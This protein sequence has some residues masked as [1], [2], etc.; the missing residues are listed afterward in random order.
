M[1]TKKSKKSAASWLEQLNASNDAEAKLTFALEAWRAEPSA[2][3]RDLVV[4]R[5]RL[6]STDVPTTPRL[7]PK[8]WDTLFKAN[9]ASD[10]PML[11]ASIVQAAPGEAVRRFKKLLTRGLD[12]RVIDT[13]LSW[14]AN[15]P[16]QTASADS[17]IFWK[18]VFTFLSKSGDATLRAKLEALDPD[19][20]GT[21]VIFMRGQIRT[22]VRALE[23]VKEP[24]LSD[25]VAALL[26]PVEE[27]TSQQR[28]VQTTASKR[29]T[30]SEAELLEAVYAAPDD[31]GP[32]LVYAD[33]LTERG[34]PWG[35][36][37]VTQIAQARG[38]ANAASQA[39]AEKLLASHAEAR[40]TGLPIEWKVRYQGA[41]RPPIFRRGFLYAADVWWPAN[42]D[43]MAHGDSRWGSIEQLRIIG[44]DSAMELATVLDPAKRSLRAVFNLSAS[45]VEA[46]LAKQ[47]P[48]LR[49]LG[50]GFLN[51]VPD[52]WLGRAFKH[53][54][55]ST[56]EAVTVD[57]LPQ[58][59]AR[60]LTAALSMMPKM[61]RISVTCRAWSY[62]DLWMLSR[63]GRSARLELRKRV[64]PAT[65]PLLQAA[66]DAI[67][68]SVDE[69]VLVSEK[70][71]KPA[72]QSKV[73][74]DA[75]GAQ[76]SRARV[77]MAP[78]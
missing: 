16:I 73:L 66:I 43:S 68:G 60:V 42:R 13:T 28:S 33:W 65:A 61:Q 20:S 52:D 10:V 29:G 4:E 75:F 1:A 23:K 53:L 44:S 30:K 71:L 48:R 11:T 56:L 50:L 63:V 12:P 51:D 57:A 15:A 9:K 18:Q 14:I 5:S 24:A 54:A 76:A 46:V 21:T 26:K 49:E 77:E 25:E 32:R 58:H 59:H 34:D 78:G 31:D 39:R 70:A 62:P 36:L 41:I 55:K 40:H 64:P 2:R 8:A 47:P 22:L 67:A 69:F 27:V 37:I 45:A 7:E 17:K 74:A 38:E 35:E 3:L 6:T 72:A 19:G